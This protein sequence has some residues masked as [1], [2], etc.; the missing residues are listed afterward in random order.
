MSATQDNFARDNNF[1]A[2]RFLGALL[3][4]VSHATFVPTGT[5]WADPLYRLSNGQMTIGWIG[6]GM[7]FAIS[8]Y[9]ITMSW[10]R[11]RGIFAFLQARALRIYPALIVVVLGIFLVGRLLSTDGAYFSNPS[12]LA[13]LANIALPFVD[14][15]LPG[16][17]QNQPSSGVSDNFWTLRYEIG[18]YL[19]IAA[20]GFLKVW[21]R[22]TILV[23][24][25]LV[26]TLFALGWPGTNNGWFDLPRYFLAGAVFYLYRDRIPWRGSLALLALG[27]LTLFAFVGGMKLAFSL[28]GTYL[29]LYLAFAPW[30]NLRR[31]GKHGDF[32]YG[33]Y[34][35]GLFVQQI[36]QGAWPRLGMV[37]NFVVSFPIVLALSVLLWYTV[38]KPALALKRFGRP[39]P[40]AT[41][42]QASD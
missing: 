27:G 29:T 38:E 32:S 3:V 42:V 11:R 4:F 31:F 9:L 37:G 21:R 41:V 30:L 33:L 36:V 10:E 1:D 5:L 7:F 12:A 2:L 39:K 16:V 18:C 14:N 25:L 35:M 22:D 34:L 40:S 19:L 15:H 23:L 26:S 17:F 13:Y 8:G 6:V 28:F 20:M 24:F